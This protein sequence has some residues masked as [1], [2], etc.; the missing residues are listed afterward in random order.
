[1][2]TKMKRWYHNRESTRPKTVAKSHSDKRDL[3][4][5][6]AWLAE[7]D[8]TIE[9][10]KYEGKEKEELLKYVRCYLRM[11]SKDEIL[12]ADLVMAVKPDDWRL[13]QSITETSTEE[14][15]V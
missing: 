11:F 9:F 6:V 4:Y 12:M 2:L 3:D 15:L 10:E 13:L 14:I 7:K 1:M 5:L 8:M